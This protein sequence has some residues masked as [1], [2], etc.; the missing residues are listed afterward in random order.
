M[1]HVLKKSHFLVACT[2]IL[3][4]MYVVCLLSQ[5]GKEANKLLAACIH[6]WLIIR[7]G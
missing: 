5:E 2:Y 1:K 4:G 7:E 3:A 6:G